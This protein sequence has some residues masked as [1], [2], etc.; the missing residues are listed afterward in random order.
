MTPLRA[1]A[2]LLFV[3]SGFC[4]LLYQVVWLR[5]AFAAFGIVTPVLSV[6]LSVFMLGLALGSWLAGRFA[7]PLAARMRRPAAVLYG[8]AEW[9]IGLGALVVPW[10]F[11][12]GEEWLLSSGEASSTG[13]LL[14]SALVIA[15][16][17]LP[18]ATL[19]G[20]TFPLMM[21]F[22]RAHDRRGEDSFSFL[23]LGNVIGAMAGALATALVLIEAIGFR[24]T[25]LVAALMNAAIGAV[26]L[27]L[28]RLLRS[29]E[30]T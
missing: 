5:L 14:W 30:H 4:S 19:M 25:L 24:R 27:L 18:F 7:E 1:L 23:Y 13:Y 17:L 26:A 20:A 3:A 9:G 6:V 8:C 16:A 2:F 10:A 28:P 11:A 21:A 12:R 29:E 15:A 22:L